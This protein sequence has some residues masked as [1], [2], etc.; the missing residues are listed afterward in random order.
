MSLYNMLNGVN[1]A[2]LHILPML[3]KHPDEY[4]RFRDCFVGQLENDKELVDQF[5]IPEMKSK[6]NKDERQ[7]SIYTRVGGGNR[8]GYIK[9]IEQLRK[10]PGY[11]TDY[12]DDFDNTYATFVFKIPKKWYKDY[13]RITKDELIS[14]EYKDQM[15]KVFP[16][17]KKEIEKLE[18]I[19]NN[20]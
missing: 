9:E 11:V 13:D 8:E 15:I 6:I 4:P 16:K 3:G 5:G 18:V 19:K 14:Q 10:M 12:D 1:P 2:T 20:E 17:L 7:I